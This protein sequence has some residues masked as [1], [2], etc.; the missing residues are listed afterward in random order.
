[1]FLPLAACLRPPADPPPAQPIAATGLGDATLAPVPPD[2]WRALGDAQ[3]D[4]L[5]ERALAD[6][7]T[8]AQAMARVHAAEAAAEAAH[9]NAAPQVAFDATETRERFSAN[10]IIPPPY[11]GATD[12]EGN[13]GLD[14]SWDLDFWGR[15]SALIA[16]ATAVAQ[17]A[18]YDAA[19]A[20]LALAGAVAEAYVAL[21]RAYAQA[22]L[23]Q[24]AEAQ[25][26]DILKLTQT[27]VTAGLD[28]ET[29]RRLAA[30]A[31]PTAAAD[32]EQAEGD[33]LRATHLLA[34]LAGEG[35]DA[36]EGLVRPVLAPDAVLKLPATLPTDLLAHRPDIAAAERRIEAARQGR[37][38]AA[39][40]FYPDIDLKALAGAS[41]IG[42]SR[43]FE[44]SSLTGGAG[45]AIHLPIFDGGRLRAA[46]RGATAAE[47]QA[48]ASYDDTVL[49]AVREVADGLS[50]L[51]TLDRQAAAIRRSHDDAAAA[52]ELAR[53][54]YGAGLTSQLT[55]LAAETQ[56]LA[57]ERRQIDIDHSRAATRIRL[58]IAIGGS[59]AANPDRGS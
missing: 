15:Q 13:A 29:E 51:A 8:L 33:R 37:K 58:L 4:R 53:S 49:R 1:L 22:D 3:L 50:D 40:A 44:A 2:W 30:G 25:R 55:V 52:Y 6:S 28:T 48:V 45:P 7:P 21:D 38:A 5:M 17:A 19:G 46:Y 36:Y 9:G 54:R 42:F 27:R 20:R 26:A 56:L 43:L 18:S 14:F 47:D 23:A 31:V 57:V 32:R 11:G 16:S 24:R 39:A 10:D 34:A 59:F 35:A 41:A 12:W